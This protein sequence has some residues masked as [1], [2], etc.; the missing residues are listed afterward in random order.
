M[1][2]TAPGSRAESLPGD[3]VV[4]RVENVSKL[5]RTPEGRTIRALQEV[6]LDVSHEEFV[7]VVGPS[8]CGKSTLLKLIAGFSAPS[9]GRIVFQN[10]E[11]RG[12]N[13]KVGYVPQES[14]L[15]PWL[16]VE[17]NVGF[18]LDA[19][20]Y[21]RARRDEQ[22]RYFINL[23]GLAGF[24]KYY[25]AQLSG[26]MSKRASIV[27]ALA[28]E[29]AVILMDEPFGPLDAQTRMVLQDEL[30]KIW[31]RK[32]QT[33]V[34]VT[35]DLVEAVALA[36]RVVVMTH[37]PG[38]IMDVIR[39]PMERP[40]NIFEIHRQAGFDEAYGRLWKIFRHELNLGARQD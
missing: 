27:R 10:E 17:Q 32:R 36:D 21:P 19:K 16:T 13:T 6:N 1:T 18:G 40:R 26:G 9:S 3:N 30:L 5:F 22:V 2:E 28:Y 39:V 37:R 31:E 20:R 12:L 11:V 33:I 35:H 34:F 7:T 4:I 23:A 15:F 24:E 38:K 29:P 25:P 8:G 14:K